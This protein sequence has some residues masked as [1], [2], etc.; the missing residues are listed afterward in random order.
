LRELGIE[1]DTLVWYC[2]DNGGLDLDPDAVGNLRGHKG[3]VFEG[4]IRVPG[5]VEWPGH[6]EPQVTD[7]PASTMDIMPT[8]VDLLELP[9]DSLLAVHDGESIA[10]LFDGKTPRRTHS[11]PFCFQKNAALIDGDYKLLSTNQRKGDE[12]RLY[13]LNND[14]GESK[15]LSTELPERF[16]RMRTEVEA[17]LRS[18]DTSAAGKDYP[19]GKVIQAPRRAFWRDMAEYKPHLE[20][21]SSRSRSSGF[22]KKAGRPSKTKKS[23]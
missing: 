1:R 22:Q 5:I 11:I 4:G 19:E 10:A 13:D 21:F 23:E 16:A 20:T 9:E 18:V 12:W 15:D 17:M 7:V 6:L 8:I 3:D 14:P 2:S